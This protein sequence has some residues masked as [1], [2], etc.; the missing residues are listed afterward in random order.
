MGQPLAASVGQWGLYAV[1]HR[2]GESGIA[3][4]Y[5]VQAKQS[6]RIKNKAI[7]A[8]VMRHYRLGGAICQE[9][10]YDS[11]CALAGIELA[12]EI[13]PD[14][15]ELLV[16]HLE[17][18]LCNGQFTKAEQD[19]ELVFLNLTNGKITDAEQI[20]QLKL[21]SAVLGW[22]ALRFDQDNDTSRLVTW[23][24]RI[25]KAAQDFG[26]GEASTWSFA[27]TITQL[28]RKPL[29][30]EMLK[31]VL[32]LMRLASEPKRGLIAWRNSPG[33]LSEKNVTPGRPA[34]R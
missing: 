18:I 5:L 1:A 2:R 25:R 20:K 21:I 6:I 10:L 15:P 12:L 22:S 17:S 27:G 29:P 16:E 3:K 7:E 11:E 14:D 33:I 34:R 32:E 4:Q 26:E 8:E 31:D 30:A 13:Q 24:G 28:N 19:A 9:T 23:E